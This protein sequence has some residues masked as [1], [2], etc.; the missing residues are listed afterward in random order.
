M[1]L[2]SIFSGPTNAS[3]EENLSVNVYGVINLSMQ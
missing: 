2:G 3:L 1:A